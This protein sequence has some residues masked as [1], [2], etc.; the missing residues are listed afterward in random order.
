VPDVVLGQLGNRIQHALRAFTPAD[1]KNVRAAAQSFRANP[2]L[3]TEAVL[4]QLGVGE[5]L[6]SVLDERGQPTVVQRAWILPPRSQIG[7]ISPEIERELINDSI[8]AGVYEAAV[9]RESAY[10]KLTGAHATPANPQASKSTPVSQEKRGFFESLFGSGDTTSTGTVQPALPS[11]QPRKGT[12][13]EPEGLGT[14][15][16]KSV[17]RSVGSSIGREIVRGVLGGI[18]GGGKRR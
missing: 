6:V 4:T 14:V 15:M 17:I 1:Q 5:A 13:R 3:D 11:A 12:H 7:P 2:R 8:V 9:D 18:F 16:A 10:E